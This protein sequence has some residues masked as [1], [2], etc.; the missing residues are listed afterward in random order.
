MKVTRILMKLFY[1]LYFLLKFRSA[2]LAYA[3]ANY[4][5]P[6]NLSQKLSRQGNYL[7]FRDTGNKLHIALAAVFQYE[8]EKMVNAFNHPDVKVLESN[9]NYA[10]V[11]VSGLKFKIRSLSNIVTLFELFIEKIYDLHLDSERIAVTDIGMNVG[12]ASLLFAGDPKVKSVKSF[13]PFPETYKEALDNFSLNPAISA[14]IVPVNK[15]ISNYVGRIEVPL[16]SS[17]DGGA[18]TNTDILD[19]KQQAHSLKIE[20]DIESVENIFRSFSEDKNADQVVKIDCEGEEYPIIDFLAE[21]GY[22]G[23]PKAYIIEWH[24]KGPDQILQKLNKAGYKSISLKRWDNMS[25]MIYA[26]K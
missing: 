13:E 22:I 10:L 15:G 12:L 6:L 5:F 2:R 24:F 16:M 9:E 20:V 26:F 25:G 19:I 7:V 21:K 23:L 14:K 17:G 8:Y 1:Y 3:F 11:E 18:S 4:H